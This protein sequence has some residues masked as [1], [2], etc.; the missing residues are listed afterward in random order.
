MSPSIVSETVIRRDAASK[1]RCVVI[2]FANCV[3]R[4]H[5][6]ALEGAR[7][8]AAEAVRSGRVVGRRKRCRAADRA[9]RREVRVKVVPD[10]REG[11]GICTSLFVRDPRP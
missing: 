6:R 8:D 11:G 1:L 4:S 3:V 9:R 5:V 7:L 2:R 10:V